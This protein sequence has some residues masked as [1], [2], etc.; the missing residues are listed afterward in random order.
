VPI[1]L[2]VSP[3]VWPG[4]RV[5]LIV[6][7]VECVAPPRTTRLSIVEVSCPV[8]AGSYPARLRVDGVDSLLVDYKAS[9][10]AYDQTQTVTLPA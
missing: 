10:P 4:Q 1:A 8:G 7:D 6:G 3:Q 2:D 9:P 5:S